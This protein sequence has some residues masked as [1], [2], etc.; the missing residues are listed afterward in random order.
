MGTMKFDNNNWL[1]TLTIITLGSFHCI[2][3]FGIEL[4]ETYLMLQYPNIMPIV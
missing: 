3:I 4:N 2:S 1:I